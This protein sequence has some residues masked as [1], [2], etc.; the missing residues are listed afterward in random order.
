MSELFCPTELCR[1]GSALLGRSPS[2]RWPRLR[3]GH[4]SPD[5]FVVV[6]VVVFILSWLLLKWATLANC[7]AG[8]LVSFISSSICVLCARGLDELGSLEISIYYSTL[9]VPYLVD[10]FSRIWTA[11]RERNRTTNSIHQQQRPVRPR[12]CFLISS[13]HN[14]IPLQPKTKKNKKVSSSRSSIGHLLFSNKETEKVSPAN[15]WERVMKSVA[16]FQLFL[17]FLSQSHTHNCYCHIWKWPGSFFLCPPWP[18]TGNLK[19]QHHHLKKNFFFFFLSSSSIW[20]TAIFS[21]WESLLLHFCVC[22]KSRGPLEMKNRVL[23]FS[24]EW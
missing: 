2:K 9:I 23:Q 20:L 16:T 11:I 3:A 13:P 18:P 19:G 14:E 5:I 21:Y 12:R 15:H 24:D 10:Y 6:V 8:R 22:S 1:G 7:I 17:S 4:F